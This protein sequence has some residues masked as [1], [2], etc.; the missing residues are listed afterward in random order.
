MRIVV[1]NSYDA[2]GQNSRQ[3]GGFGLAT[4]R[5]RLEA[6]YGGAAALHTSAAE[7]IYRVELR[8]PADEVS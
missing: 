7:G 2:D 5:K 4:V 8:L 1:E 3:R 6:H